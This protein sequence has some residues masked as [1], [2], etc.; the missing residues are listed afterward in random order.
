MADCK[1]VL[2]SAILTANDAG[3]SVVG[4]PVIAPV[5][6][7][8]INPV[9]NAFEFTDQMYGL[10]PPWATN[11]YEYGS[12]VVPFGTA[13][14]MMFNGEDTMSENEREIVW[15]GLEPSATVIVV[16][17]DPITV[18]VPL[19]VPTALRVSPLGRPTALQ[20]TGPVPPWDCSVVV[21]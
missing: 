9:G 3:P 11:V 20:V 4:V 15:R 14:V 19:K 2:L 18:G 10:V 7:F 6:G 17:N 5:V 16:V 8:S 13:V 12:R 1:G 21:G